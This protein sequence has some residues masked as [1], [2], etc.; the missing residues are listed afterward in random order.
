M[1][2]KSS[3][4]VH[5]GARGRDAF[6]EH[7]DIDVWNTT[8]VLRKCPAT[9]RTEHI[10]ISG[11]HSSVGCWIKWDMLLELGP[12]VGPHMHN[13]ALSK[14]KATRPCIVLVRPATAWSWMVVVTK[15]EAYAP[16]FCV[17]V[18]AKIGLGAM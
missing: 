9:R 7:G 1:Y 15:P 8:L 6:G 3:G 17:G 5:I 12:N 10:L 16:Q 14:H 2:G 4:R 18:A 11:M 13:L